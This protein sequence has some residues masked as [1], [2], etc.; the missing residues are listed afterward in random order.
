MADGRLSFCERLFMTVPMRH[1]TGQ[2]WDIGH[3]EVVLVAPVEGDLV[4]VHGP[5]DSLEDGCPGR[6]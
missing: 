2:L 1:A 4:L 5:R 6:T 3:E